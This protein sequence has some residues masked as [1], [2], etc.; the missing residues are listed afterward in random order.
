M[1]EV[2]VNV[3]LAAIVACAAAGLGLAKGKEAAMTRRQ[4]AMLRRILA[5]TAL[6]LLL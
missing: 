1:Q 2:I 3:L 5:A 6:L 4:A